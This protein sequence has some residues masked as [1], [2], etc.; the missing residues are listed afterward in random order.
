MIYKA[1]FSPAGTTKKIVDSVADGVGHGEAFDLLSNPI[2][3]PVSLSSSDCLVIGVPVF[4]GRIPAVCTSSIKNL[5][6]DNTP[7]IALVSFGN[8]DF[9]DA[10]L[11]LSELLTNSGFCVISAAAVVAQHSIFT[12]VATGR[13]D[14]AD[15]AKL[16]TFAQTCAEKL[17]SFTP[18]TAAKIKIPGQAPYREAGSVPL[19]PSGNKNC[20]N[21]GACVK[22]CPVGAISKDT[23]RETDKDKCITCMAC[24]NACPTKARALR[25]PLYLAAKTAFK[26]KCGARLEPK[27]FTE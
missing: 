22:I 19:K 21:C 3:A 2:T 10:L 25:G 7:A 6:G 11:E 26:K 5:R 13:P 14:S 8:R 20:N 1:Y 27:F 17:A 9:D 23:P 18:K 4:A 15:L 12:N 16:N 24:V